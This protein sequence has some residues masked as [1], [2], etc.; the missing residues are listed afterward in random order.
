VLSRPMSPRD[1][2]REDGTE[3]GTEFGTEPGGV[4]RD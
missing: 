1:P 4:V 3:P 2:G